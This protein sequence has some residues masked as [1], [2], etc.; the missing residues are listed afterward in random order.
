[1]PKPPP[2]GLKSFSSSGDFEKSKHCRVVNGRLPD[3]N[4]AEYDDAG[5]QRLADLS[6]RQAD[7]AK[8][9]GMRKGLEEECLRRC[10]AVTDELQRRALRAVRDS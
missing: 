4:L 9:Q 5:L 10:C 6:L 3:I 7:A 8:A 1:M 2:E